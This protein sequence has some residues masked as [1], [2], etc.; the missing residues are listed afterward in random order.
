[1]TVKETATHYTALGIST[2]PIIA[3]GSK[4][5]AVE[6]NEYKSRLAR[7]D[8]IE[9]WFASG[10]RGI[11]IVCGKVSGNLE[12]IDFDAP[13]LAIAWIKRVREAG[14]YDA[15]ERLLLVQTPSPGGAHFVYRCPEGIEGSQKLALRKA[16]DGKIETLIETRGEAS[17]I[18]APGSPP[19]CHELNKPYEVRRGSFKRIPVIA[20]KERA[21]LLTVARSL[22]EYVKPKKIFSERHAPVGDRPGDRFNVETSWEEILGPHGWSLIYSQNGTGHWQRPDKSGAGTSATT[23]HDGS[24]LF[25]VFS[26]NGTPFE[27]ETAYTKFAAYTVLDFDGDFSAAARALYWEDHPRQ[28]LPEPLPNVPSL[29][30]E[31]L[32]EAIRPWVVDIAERLQVPL[33]FVAVPAIVAFTAVVG[34]KVGIRPKQHDDWTVVPNLWGALVARPG[35]LKSPALKEALKPLERLQIAANEKYEKDR[36]EAEAQLEIIEAQI[37]AIKKEIKE[38]ARDRR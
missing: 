14:G 1:M 6:W 21:L 12:V 3:D 5:A 38:L 28:D 11:G 16:P 10:R 15:V 35:M 36:L 25:Y 24:D 20:A 8:E 13:G 27:P 31:W 17:Y 32:P 33:E 37:T 29:S 18:V 4:K 26:S 34:R 2:I 9:S 7:L 30:A 19:E 22:N 23:N